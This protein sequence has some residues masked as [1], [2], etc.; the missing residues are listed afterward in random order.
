MLEALDGDL[1]DE[2]GFTKNI[3][4]SNSKNYQIW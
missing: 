4:K 1:H 3:A 2:L